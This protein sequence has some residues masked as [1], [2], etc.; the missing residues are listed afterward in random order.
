MTLLI[1][2]CTEKLEN[3]FSLSHRTKELKPITLAQ[4]A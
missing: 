3:Q 2:K 4:C 1:L